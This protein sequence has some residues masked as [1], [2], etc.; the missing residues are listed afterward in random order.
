MINKSLTLDKALTSSLV[1]NEANF[2][3]ATHPH[4]VFK[5][6]GFAV[7]TQASVSSH[8]HQFESVNQTL[9]VQREWTGIKPENISFIDT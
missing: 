7:W 2:P 4:E 8:R 3:V 1:I 6:A 9:S 5:Q